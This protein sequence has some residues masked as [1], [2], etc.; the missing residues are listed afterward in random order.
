[1]YRLDDVVLNF[2]AKNASSAEKLL[3]PEPLNQRASMMQPLISPEPPPPP[4]PVFPME[5]IEPWQGMAPYNFPPYPQPSMYPYNN[6]PQQY[7]VAPVTE[8][9]LANYFHQMQNNPQLS[10]ALYNEGLIDYSNTNNNN[11]ISNP[12]QRIGDIYE[13]RNL[14]DVVRLHFVQRQR[15]RYNHERLLERYSRLRAPYVS[16][17]KTYGTSSLPGR[18]Y[19]QYL[20]EMGGYGGDNSLGANSVAAWSRAGIGSSDETYRWMDQNSLEPLPRD[21]SSFMQHTR[22]YPTSIVLA[23]RFE[24]VK[25]YNHPVFGPTPAYLRP[26]Y[27]KTKDVKPKQNI[28]QQKIDVQKIPPGYVIYKNWKDQY[29]KL[30]PVNPVLFNVYTERR[31]GSIKT[32]GQS[33]YAPSLSLKN[34]KQETYYEDTSN[35]SESDGETKPLDKYDISSVN[36]YNKLHSISNYKDE[37]KFDINCTYTFRP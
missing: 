11:L 9:A 25:I 37:S 33:L 23:E 27:K 17:Y 18:N 31:N 24:P 14:N 34:D 20:Q 28:R 29:D 4:P 6:E 21:A 5:N 22:D 16:Q 36:Q 10:P 15:L 7:P 13:N 1:M 3:F 32:Y 8:M 12:N 35:L 2:S 26:I 19:D 30:I